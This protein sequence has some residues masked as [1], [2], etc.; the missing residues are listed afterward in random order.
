MTTTSAAEAVIVRFEQISE[1]SPNRLAILCLNRPET[2]NAFDAAMIEAITSGLERIGTEKD[3]RAL[4]LC[5][6]GKHFSSGADLAWMKASARLGMTENFRDAEKLTAMFEALENL[7]IPTI[8]VIQ[9]AAFGGAVGLAACCDIA[10]AYESAKFCLSE[11]KLGIV[12]AV[13]YPYLAR[14]IIPGQLKRLSLTAR[15]FTGTEAKDFGL[16]QLTCTDATL[17]EVLRGELNGLLAAGPAAIERLKILQRRVLKEGNIQGEYTAR[18][19]SVA[20]IEPEAQSGFEAF[21]QKQLPP[22]LL[23][24]DEDWTFHA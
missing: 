23:E 14:K 15:V 17:H 4:I 10:I 3:I 2:A 6:Q 12:P 13:I 8:A 20:R 1:N 22:W 21:F 18:C 9:G 11:V 16:V 5:G 7:P 19:I 24:L